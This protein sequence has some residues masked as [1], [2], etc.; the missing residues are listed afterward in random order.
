MVGIKLQP[1]ISTDATGPYH[2][3]KTPNKPD[4]FMLVALEHIW[5]TVRSELYTMSQFKFEI[6]I[7]LKSELIILSLACIWTL[8]LPGSKPSCKPLSYDDFIKL[9][10]IIILNSTFK[11]T[12]PKFVL[13]LSS[14][15]FLTLNE[16]S[17]FGSRKSF[18]FLWNFNNYRILACKKVRFQFEERFG[19]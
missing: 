13:M 6:I 8:G 16:I 4:L 5:M 10:R 18:K 9:I 2:Q 19:L 11:L 3:E 1:P 14:S 15:P 12:F 7:P 17:I